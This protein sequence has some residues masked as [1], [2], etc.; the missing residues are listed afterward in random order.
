MVAVSPAAAAARTRVAESSAQEWSRGRALTWSR[1]GA[2]SGAGEEGGEIVRAVVL[3]RGDEEGDVREELTQGDIAVGVVA[4]IEDLSRLV[5]ADDEA[6]LLCLG[7]EGARGDRLIGVEAAIEGEDAEPRFAPRDLAEEDRALRVTRAHAILFV[8]RVPT[9]G[10]VDPIATTRP[11]RGA[12]QGEVR[13]RQRI[14]RPGHDADRAGRRGGSTDLDGEIGFAGG[15]PLD[16]PPP[17]EHCRGIL[18]QDRSRRVRRVEVGEQGTEGAEGMFRS[19][20]IEERHRRFDG[21]RLAL[22]GHRSKPLTSR[23]TSSADCRRASIFV[24]RRIICWRTLPTVR[25]CP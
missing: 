25:L 13:V 9:E 20:H 4:R 6:N 19:E 22:G 23:C 17:S 21:C 1:N 18:D 2:F 24:L 16:S 5:E 12:G 15:R 11:K 14:E 10:E 3:A 8:D 7:E